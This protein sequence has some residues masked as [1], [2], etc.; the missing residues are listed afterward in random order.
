M[1]GR[2]VKFRFHASLVSSWYYKCSSSG[3][4]SGSIVY[5]TCIADHDMSAEIPQD[6]NS[7][8]VQWLPIQWV[9]SLCGQC[10]CKFDYTK[11]HA[12]CKCDTHVI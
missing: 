9:L 11:T 2:A 12:L 5:I 8:Y 1:S 10:N 7:V 3:K 4:Q 6:S